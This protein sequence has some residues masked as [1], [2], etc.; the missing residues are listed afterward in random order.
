MRPSATQWG[1]DGLF[2]TCSEATGYSFEK[3]KRP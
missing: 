2:N 1:K 3:K